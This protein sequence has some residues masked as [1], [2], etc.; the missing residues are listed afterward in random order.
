M[1]LYEV[2]G[3]PCESSVPQ[4]LAIGKFDGVHIGHQA[5]LDRA[6]QLLEPGTRLAVM[7]FEPHPTYVLS[8]KAEYL[9]LLTPRG[10]KMRVLADH[11]VDALYVVQFNDAYAATDPEVFV[12][13]HLGCLHLKHIV[14]GPDFRFGRG[15]KGTVQLLTEWATNMGVSVHVVAPVEE[16]RAKVSSSQ[17]RAHLEQGRVEAVEMLLG[18]PY[19][20]TGPVIHGDERG[21]TIGFPTANLG[22]LDEYVM[23]KSGV[24]AV[25]VAIPAENG[26]S[27]HWFGVLNAGYR[28][29]V[30]G[31]DF[32]LEVHLLGFNGDLYGK[33]CRVSFLHRIRDERKFSGL[34]ELKDQIASDCTTAREL[35]GLP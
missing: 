8:G 24:Y 2:N 18:R 15:G 12:K 20:V 28:P 9:R 33:Q 32:R 11:G 26:G 7:C 35:L 23:P 3:L 10:E 25:A 27:E 34:D 29:T 30:N 6:R 1:Q 14:V 5:I 22:D 21:R 13:E 4:V 31:Q 19:S 16:N 17:I